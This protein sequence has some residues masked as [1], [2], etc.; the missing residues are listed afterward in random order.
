MKDKITVS[1][2]IIILFS[3]SLTIILTKD[4]SLSYYE[5]RKLMDSNELK[6]NFTENID[7]YLSDQFP[8]RDEFISLSETYERYLLGIK[9]SK[10]AYIVD[11]YIIEKNYP[12]N[13]KNVNDFINKINYI[14]NEYL[15]NSNVFYTVIP[16]KSYYLSDNYLRV[17]F[18]S[19]LNKLNKYLNIEY[20]DIKDYLELKDYYKTDIHLKQEYYINIIK[21]LS[22]HLNFEYKEY[23]YELKSYNNFYGSSYSKVPKFI[24][25][26]KLEWM[27]NDTILNAKVTHLEYG[28]G[29]L[30][31][32]DELK[33]IDAYNLF[34]KGPSSLIEIENKESDSDRELIIFRDSFASSMTPLLIPYY[35]K[36]TL[37][38]LR[39]IKMDIVND[40]LDFKNKDVLFIYSTLIINSS[41]L[42]KVNIK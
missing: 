24:N 31:E 36:I 9:D 42:L 13:E 18:N 41:N 27:V 32:E 15:K 17:D 2:F 35:K 5:R 14:N 1:L 16:D 4:R 33:K 39:Y 7:T 26:D 40:L 37:V 19:L 6:E 20:I 11:D 21:E 30:Y 8:L 22:N 10:N 25:S 12:L 38:D 29:R 28:E 34:L 3:F 23:D